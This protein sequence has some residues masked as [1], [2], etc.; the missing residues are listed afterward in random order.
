MNY[1]LKTITIRDKILR[2]QVKFLIRSLGIKCIEITD[3]L[4]LDINLNTEFLYSAF[5][6]ELHDTSPVY[7]IT[8]DKDNKFL[9]ASCII[10]N[11]H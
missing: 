7:N 4:N 8:V 11:G 2:D 3:T 6:A 5:T 10:L 9:S 1:V